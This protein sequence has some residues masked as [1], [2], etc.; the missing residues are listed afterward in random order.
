MKLMK[1]TK[2]KEKFIELRAKGLSY[3]K[4]A[5][6]LDTSKPTLMKWVKEF[7]NE[8]SEL[9][10]IELEAML[11]RYKMLKI[12]RVRWYGEQLEL[13]RGAL[14]E[15]ELKDVSANKLLDMALQLE[16]RIQ[17][18]TQRVSHASVETK[19]YFDEPLAIGETPKYTWHIE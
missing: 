19:Q 7:E 17:A 13:I 18:E 11:E 12:E 2:T 6:E 4:I 8:I 10:F 14:K 5:Q 15:S 1:D 16:N 9:K 3:D